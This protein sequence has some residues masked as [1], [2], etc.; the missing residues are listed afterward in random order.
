MTTSFRGILYNTKADLLAG[1][2]GEW[3]SGTRNPFP[4]D[5]VASAMALVEFFKDSPEDDWLDDLALTFDDI[6]G[7]IPAGTEK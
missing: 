7:A 2:V 6:V 4:G 3:N 1:I 5:S